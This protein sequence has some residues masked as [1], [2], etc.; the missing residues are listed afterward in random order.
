MPKIKK[1]KQYNGAKSGT[2]FSLK[3][4]CNLVKRVGLLILL[5]RLFSNC[6]NN[7]WLF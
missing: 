5:P 4:C 6:S 2:N 1:V 3:V 7:K